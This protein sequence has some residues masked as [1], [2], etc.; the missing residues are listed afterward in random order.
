MSSPLH[1]VLFERRRRDRSEEGN[2]YVV[3]DRSA[4]LLN[5]DAD[6]AGDAPLVT[7]SAAHEL[8][9]TLHARLS[10]TQPADAEPQIFRGKS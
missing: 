4:L 9:P 2:A 1:S 10:R 5:L 3:V 7:A 6:G 8:S